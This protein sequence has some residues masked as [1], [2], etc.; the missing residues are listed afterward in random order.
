M[1]QTAFFK[2]FLATLLPNLLPLLCSLGLTSRWEVT[3]TVKTREDGFC[4]KGEKRAGLERKVKMLGGILGFWF[5]V[6]GDR[7][8][9]C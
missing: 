4:G 8:A 1:K 6:E 5:V 2:D 3:D 7:G 9:I